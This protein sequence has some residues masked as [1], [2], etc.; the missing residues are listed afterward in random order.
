MQDIVNCHNITIKECD[1]DPQ[2]VFIPESEG[3]RTI[4]GP[5]LQTVDVTKPLKLREVNIGTTEQPK[6]AKIGDYWDDD[7]V[8]KVVEFLIEYRNLFPTNF[9]ELKGIIGDLGVMRITLKLDACP[10]KKKPSRLNPKYKQKVRDEI[11]KMLAAGIIESVEQSDWVSS[12]VVQEKK[13]KGEIHI[14]VDL[15]K[16]NDACVHDPFLMPFLD[17]ILDSVGGQE[18]Y[19]FTNGFS[20]YHQIRIAPEDHSKT[21]FAT[22]WGSFQYTV[23]PF[24]LKNAPVIFSRVV[25]AVFKE[26]IHKFLEVYF[27]DWIVFFW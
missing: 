15:R 18:A 11:D 1:E 23:M 13:I 4:A 2:N 17:E 3:E 22:E 12:M 24:R 5:P 16:L 6:L 7:N 10:I 20:G 26:L 25:V 9:S 14:C 19:S 27:D 8:S 21:K